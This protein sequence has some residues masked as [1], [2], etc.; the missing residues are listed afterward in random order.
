MFKWSPE[1]VVGAV[2]LAVSTAGGLVTTAIHWG[3]TNEQIEQVRQNQTTI[4]TKLDQHQRELASE[5][6]NQAVVSQKLDDMIARL[7]RIEKKL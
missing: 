1:A 3:I 2:A 5:Q 6:Q 7:D 4:E